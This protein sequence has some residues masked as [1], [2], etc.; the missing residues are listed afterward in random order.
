MKSLS[1]FSRSVL[2]A[3]ASEIEAVK[4]NFAES[5]RAIEAARRAVEKFTDRLTKVQK[6]LT[7]AER[8]TA[9]LRSGKKTLNPKSFRQFV[10]DALEHGTK[11]VDELTSSA[12]GAGYVSTSKNS[13]RASIE[14]ACRDLFSTGNVKSVGNSTFKL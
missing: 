6:G 1:S 13:L 7:K 9:R 5:A 10:L 2:E 14:R 12:R 8:G 11:T 3:N 4:S